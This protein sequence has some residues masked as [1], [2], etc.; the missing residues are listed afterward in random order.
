M[1][2]C[3][4]EIDNQEY[5]AQACIEGIFI[6]PVL[7]EDFWTLPIKDRT[8][9]NMQHWKGKPFII[10]DDNNFYKVY[11]L[12]GGSWD[13]PSLKGGFDSQAKAID[14]IIDRYRNL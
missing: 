9:E 8:E 5:Y 2:A 12:D 13:R 3:K 14:F 10:T 4:F 11:C 1:K 7:P 6:N